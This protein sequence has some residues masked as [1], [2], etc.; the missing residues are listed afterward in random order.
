MTRRAGKAPPGGDQAGTTNRREDRIGAAAARRAEREAKIAERRATVAQRRAIA[1]RRQAERRASRGVKWSNRE[2][3]P[4][5]LAPFQET[6][7]NIQGLY[8]FVAEAGID[9]PGILVGRNLLSSGGAAPAAELTG[10]PKADI[11]AAVK[12][13]DRADVAAVIEAAKPT[14]RRRRN[15][16]EAV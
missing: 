11:E 4:M 12:R 9:A 7:A 10:L 14:E 8:P 3:V 5:R 15:P 6:T 13:V 16:A 1:A 2:Y